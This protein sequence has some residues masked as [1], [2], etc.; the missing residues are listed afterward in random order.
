VVRVEPTGSQVPPESAS[1]RFV[2]APVPSE[3]P[4][5][6]RADRPRELPDRTPRFEACSLL[7]FSLTTADVDA[8]FEIHEPTST[9]TVTMYERETGE[10]LREVPSKYLLDVIAS[11]AA[12]GLRVDTTS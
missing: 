1:R 10:V 7:K 5:T 6:P 9:V 2:R 4:E 8:K 12:S 11:V 3:A